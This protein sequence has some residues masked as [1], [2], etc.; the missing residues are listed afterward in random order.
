MGWKTV[1]E[2]ESD[3]LAEDSAYEKRIRAAQKAA[4]AKKAIAGE[5]EVYDGEAEGHKAT[6][7][8]Q[9]ANYPTPS[10]IRRPDIYTNGLLSLPTGIK[11]HPRVIVA[12]S[13]RLHY[14]LGRHFQLLWLRGE[15]TPSAGLPLPGLRPSLLRVSIFHSKHN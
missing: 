14:H 8:I 9:G 7:F 13:K 11:Q 2:Y 5:G 6:H 4:S 3:N 10:A 12:L 1:A 15:G